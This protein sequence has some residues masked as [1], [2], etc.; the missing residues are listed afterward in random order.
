[1]QITFWGA[2]R[3]VT[4]SCFLLE[5]EGHKFLVD[6]GMFQ[7]NKALKQR[8]YSDFPFNPA[9]ID[10]VL[11]THAHI[12]HSG[13]LPKLCKHGF[14]GNIWATEGTVDLCSVMLPDSAHIQ[15]SEVEQKNRRLLRAGQ[16]TIEPI[17]TMEDAAKTLTLFKGIKYHQLVKPAENIEVVFYDAGHIL[18]SSVIQIK[19]TEAGHEQ[20]VVFSGDLGRYEHYILHD[21]DN[22]EKA[23]Y[24]VM[25]STYG[26]RFHEEEKS[27]EDLAKIINDTFKRGGNVIIPA[28]AVDRCQDIIMHLNSLVEAGLMKQGSIY[29]DSPLS[30]KATDIFCDHPEYFDEDTKALAEKYGTCPLKTKNIIFSETTEDSIALNKVK[31]GA[32]IIS[33]SG[34]AD[35][36]RIKHHLRHNLW[37]PE[38]TVLF[39]GY[40]AEGTL[41]RRLVNGEKIVRIHGEEID[42]KA[43]IVALD[44]YSAH[45]DQTE[46]LKWLSNIKEK[47]QN[48]FLVHGEESA[49]GQFAEII[50][51]KTGIATLIPEMGESYKL[52]DLA[53]FVEKQKLAIDESGDMM[54][55]YLDINQQISQM[56]RAK[57]WQKLFD[58]KEFLH[59]IS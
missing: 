6:C 33:A 41:G 50:S 22:I 9:E 36:G 28:F 35:A 48:I 42:V 34:M 20:I 53:H 10:F 52:N 7:G 26:I 3:T 56:M 27:K 49:M 25:E 57:E 13:L 1:M 24:L 30:V 46:M 39:V 8:N 21:P 51:Q 5:H 31:S 43:Q 55:L 11:L 58:I 32:I 16:P 40:Q 2:A 47:P 38:S 37:R 18:G 54:E 23:D 14:K 29:V 44:G 59:K 17:Y 15:E 45:G 12:D 4:G 19:Y